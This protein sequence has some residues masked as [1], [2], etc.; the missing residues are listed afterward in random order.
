MSHLAS[1]NEN[2]NEGGIWTAIITPFDQRGEIDWP[3]YEKILQQQ[4]DAKVTGV[5]VSGTTGESPTLT[6]QEKLSLIK[7]AVAVLG[8]KIRIMAGTGSNNT[9][10]S[11]ELSK[12]AVDAG[13]DSLLIVNPYYNKPCLAGLKK[14]YEVIKTAAKVPLC[15]YYIPSRTGLTLPV[16][17]LADLVN[18]LEIDMVK[19]SSGDIVYFSELLSLT[20]CTMLTGDDPM[21]IPTL[22]LGGRGAISAVANVFPSEFVELYE[23]FTNGRH[24]EAASLNK[25]LIKIMRT[26]FIES[27][28]G[29]IKAMLKLRGTCD[30]FMRL[31]MMSVTEQSL[32]KIREDLKTTDSALS[33]KK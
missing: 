16:A 6:V 31:P 29:P 21:L 18:S 3:A 30:D 12:L 1:K 10:Q 33:S 17:Q 20:N 4:A 11:V 13:A 32:I 5:V 25:N 2:T 9:Q 8:G 14:H 23:L 26:A 24:Q 15:L 28:P 22:A 19:E 7:K 27:N